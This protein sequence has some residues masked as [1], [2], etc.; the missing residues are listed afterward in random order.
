MIF[1]LKQKSIAISI[2]LSWKWLYFLGNKNKNLIDCEFTFSFF[3][4]SLN[5]KILAGTDYSDI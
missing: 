4:I 2:I 3:L 1:T 5:K